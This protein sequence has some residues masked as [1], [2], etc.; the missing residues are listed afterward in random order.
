MYR[1]PKTRITFTG[2]AL[3]VFSLNFREKKFCPLLFN[4]FLDKI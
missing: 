3:A 4:I 1:I 2:E